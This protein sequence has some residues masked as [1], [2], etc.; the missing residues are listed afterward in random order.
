MRYKLCISTII[1]FFLAN[2]LW[3]QSTT[4]IIYVNKRLSAIVPNNSSIE[5]IADGFKFVEGPVWHESGYLLFSDIPSNKIMKYIPNEGVSIFMENSG[6]TGSD[7]KGDGPGSNGLTL[8][9]KGDLIICQH[10][11]RQVVIQDITGNIKPIA[12]Q[13]GGKRLNSPNDAVMMSN[14]SI[15]FTDPPWGLPKNADDPAKELKFQGVFRLR[16]GNLDIIDRDL[17][18][19]NG[20]ALSADE[21]SLFVAET[22]GSSRLYYQYDVNEDGEVSG[23]RVFFDASHLKEPGSADGIKLDKKGNCYFTGPGGVLIINSKGQHLGTI[24]PPELPANIGWGGKDGKTL[25]MTCRTGLY[26][27]KLKIAGVRPMD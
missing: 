10:G 7:E 6:F 11:A 8:S 14:G 15:F 12:R 4:E 24:K 21:R 1:L 26:A 13:F 20:I 2:Q 25:Y 16:N 3:S 18:L 17:I 5:K 22:K 27:I 9:K 19:P 23:K